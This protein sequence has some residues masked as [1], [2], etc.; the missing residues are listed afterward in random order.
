MKKIK[1]GASG[2]K[3]AKRRFLI[4]IT[5]I[6]RNTPSQA[7]FSSAAKRLDVLVVSITMNGRKR[8]V[9]VIY[10]ARQAIQKYVSKLDGGRLVYANPSRGQLG[11][12]I[13]DSA[14]N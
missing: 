13:A 8:K 7:M 6:K 11:V 10:G 1:D 3:K 4:S 2:P 9:T 14:A 5:T 12:V